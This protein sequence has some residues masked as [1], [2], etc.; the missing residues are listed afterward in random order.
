MNLRLL[1]LFLFGALILSGLSGFGRTGLVIRSAGNQLSWN[2]P[3]AWSIDS[4]GIT[5]Q[6]IPQGDDTIIISHQIL[7]ASDFQLLS[8]KLVIE[9]D[10]SLDAGNASIEF[11]GNSAAECYGSLSIG[12]LRFTAQSTFLLAPSGK[13]TVNGMLHID[14]GSIFNLQS[15]LDNHGSLITYG[16]VEGVISAGYDVLAN[17]SKLVT[18]PVNGAES[19][20]FLNMYLRNYSE[21]LSDW[22][23]YIVPTTIPMSPM[24]GFE[25]LSTY[26]D[27]REFSGTPL[28]GEQRIDITSDGDG[29][30]LIGNPYPS[31][32]NWNELGS[33]NDAG[34]YPLGV[35]TIYYWDNSGSG[36]YSVFCP[37][38]EPVGIN[39]GT[40]VIAPMQGFFIKT[41]YPGNLS[42]TNNMRTHDSG[43]DY[44]A[45]LS[46]TSLR[47]RIEGNS[48]SDEAVIRFNPDA[49]A[50]FDIAFDAYELQ[51]T[52]TAPGI[53]STINDAT[54]LAIN[55]L[56]SIS[57]GLVIPIQVTTP[58]QGT[59]TLRIEGA[60]VF[61]Y[62]YPIYLEDL[63]TGIYV[64]LRADSVYYFE[65]G[66]NG[67]P[68]HNFKIHFSSPGSVD[69]PNS[70]SIKI[71]AGESSININ[72]AKSRTG[73][74]EVFT[75]DGKKVYSQTNMLLQTLIIPVSPEKV[76]ITRIT[77][78]DGV[79]TG[80]LYCR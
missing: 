77:T 10:G 31:N 68:I 70:S 12:N 29:W 8:G 21:S 30:N 67:N 42:V 44:I 24:Q 76:Y 20:V 13:V 50:Q 2:D 54:K 46:T 51:G 72:D 74:I 60:S 65:S 25:V 78:V 16:P 34:T 32:I 17:V 47:F 79:E 37:G 53:Y 6:V 49:T 69:E 73:N 80:K 19:G 62:R 28:N 71:T 41:N 15:L 1:T 43:E 63:S 5:G 75:T 40:P 27:H 38:E 33:G 4:S 11:S 36:N 14:E 64:D 23:E 7:L 9:N 35:N 45:Q 39:H 48:Y 66:N 52:E 18:S 3:M 22:G 61:Q 58:Y 26:N 55:T 59:S 56:G 57:S